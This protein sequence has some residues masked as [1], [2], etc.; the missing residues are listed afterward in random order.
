MC[1]CATD[2]KYGSAFFAFTFPFVRKSLEAN[3]ANVNSDTDVMKQLLDYVTYHVNMD[4]DEE[5]ASALYD[6]EI[7]PRLSLMDILCR[8]ISTSD[9]QT[10]RP[11]ACDV[12]LNACYIS[13]GEEG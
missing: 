10:T 3:G 5:P 13:S 11:V 8:L 1:V 7:V 12:L 6:V 2:S 9:E 4:D